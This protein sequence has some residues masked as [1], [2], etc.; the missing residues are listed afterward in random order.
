[1]SPYYTFIK[2]RPRKKKKKKEKE[3]NKEKQKRKKE[4][5]EKKSDTPQCILLDKRNRLSYQQNQHCS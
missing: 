5:K 4:R 2:S 3:K 1:M